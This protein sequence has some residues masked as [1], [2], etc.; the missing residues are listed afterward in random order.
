[1]DKIEVI[2]EDGV[3]FVEGLRIQNLVESTNFDDYESLQYFQRALRKYG[4]IDKLEEA[5]VKEGD[6]VNIYDFE[7]DYV[8]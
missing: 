7:F 5:G 6:L 2:I 1:M 8:K 3:F 4:V